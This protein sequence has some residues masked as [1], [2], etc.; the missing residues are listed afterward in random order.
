MPC[1]EVHV[2][3][4]NLRP[5]VAACAGLYAVLAFGAS[6]YGS[7]RYEPSGVQYALLPLLVA[8]ACLALAML[9]ASAARK[10]GAP[11]VLAVLAYASVAVFALPAFGLLLSNRNLETGRRAAIGVGV[12]HGLV[13][14]AFLARRARAERR[15]PPA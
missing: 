8:P 10:A 6:I 1:T 3:I 13:L 15:L 7:Y 2:R 5:L 14:A 9:I 4:A 12:A 11:R